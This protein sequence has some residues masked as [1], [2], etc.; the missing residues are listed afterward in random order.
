V[1]KIVFSVFSLFSIKFSVPYKISFMYYAVCT[2]LLYGIQP[3]NHSF[4]LLM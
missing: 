2:G 4:H 3:H 1:S